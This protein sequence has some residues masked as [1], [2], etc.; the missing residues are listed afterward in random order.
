MNEMK[1]R[2]PLKLRRCG[3]EDVVGV[4]GALQ[5]RSVFP[6]P[7]GTTPSW[8]PRPDEHQVVGF[9]ERHRKVRVQTV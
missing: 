2:Q 4:A 7:Y 9:V 6:S 5:R 1:F 3:I 8:I